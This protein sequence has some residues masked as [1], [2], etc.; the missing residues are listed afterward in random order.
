MFTQNFV[1]GISSRTVR[2]RVRQMLGSTLVGALLLGAVLSSSAPVAAQAADTAGTVAGATL[3]WGVKESFRAYIGGNIAKGSA[4]PLGSVSATET[5]TYVWSNGAGE[6]AIDG[7]AGSIGFGAEDGVRFQGHSMEIDGQEISVLDATF[8]S[9]RIVITSP[10]SGELRMNVAGYAFESTTELGEPFSLTDAPIASLVLPAPTTDGTTLTWAN[11]P[12]SLTEQGALAFGG[13]AFYSAGAALDPVSFS[14]PLET[15]TVP[16]GE[17]P[18]GETPA[19]VS[20]AVTIEGQSTVTIASG[21]P[22]TFIADLSPVNASG[23]IQF[24]ANGQPLGAPIAPHNGRA[25]LT[26]NELKVGTHS[27]TA[28]FVPTDPAAFAVSESRAHTINVTPASGGTSKV[29]NATLE[30]G[31]RESFRKYIYDFTAFKGRAQLLGTTKQPQPKGSYLWTGGVGTAAN[32]GTRANVGFGPGNGVHFQSHPMTVGGKSV[33]ALDLKFTNPRIEILSPTAGLLH[34]DV[35]GYTFEGMES[36]GKKFTLRDTPMAQL[37]LTVPEIDENSS[38]LS[39]SNVG[40]RLT[41]EGEVAFGGFYEKGSEL[42]PLSFS[43]PGHFAIVERQ[44]TSVKLTA[45]PTSAKAG[46]SVA[47]TATVTP[48]IDGEVTFSYGTTQLGQPV[49]VTN[50]VAKFSTTKLPE[51]VYTAQALFEPADSETFSHS[52][53]NSVKMT[54][55]SATT[56]V[57]PKPTAPSTG[58]G[59]GSLKWGISSQFAGYTT[60]K[61]NTAACPTAGKHCAGGEIATSGVG[62]GYLFPQSGSTWNAKTQTGTVNYSGSVSFKGYGT[63]M[64][65]VVNPTITVTGPTT[66]TLTTGYSGSYGPSSVQLDLSGAAKS[67]GPGGEVTWNNVPVLGSLMGLSA[68]QSIA[69]DRLSFTVGAASKVSYGSTVAGKDAKEKRVAAATPPATEGLTI[70]SDKDKLVPG[71][72][73]EIQ[74]AGFD[75]GDEGVLVVL[76]SEP[77]VLDEEATADKFGVVHWTGKLPDDI[78]LGSHVLTLQGSAD[79][80]AKF[81]ILPKEKKAKKAA[82]EQ[83]EVTALPLAVATGAGPALGVGGSGMALWEWWVVALSLVAIAGCTTTLAVRQRATNR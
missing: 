76:Y 70:V 44:P 58:P 47:F 69:F 48:R 66:A 8:T 9:P 42:D 41:A 22:A 6:V 24:A 23:V 50:G 27:I 10:T 73:I 77:I 1:S 52:T 37:S 12:A 61:S 72:R 40:A 43:L 28:H 30:W 35:D 51:G 2:A 25:T 39:W 75:P 31:V 34:M 63:T 55:D 53:S 15:S 59:A 38:L 65:Q 20:T 14:L 78:E 46:A 18:G 7:S 83:L 21:K 56:P 19:A 64:F 16:G 13:G 11:V 36:V 68:S 81:T 26:T 82:D 5:G 60:A 71:A 49:T 74:A 57:A 54:I 32:D 3:E 29:E 33:Y 4:T 67:V 80:G 17:N 79:V 62:S 45:T